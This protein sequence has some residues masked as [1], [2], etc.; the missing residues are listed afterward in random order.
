[1]PG[2]PGLVSIPLAYPNGS[3]CLTEIRYVLDRPFGD[4]FLGRDWGSS[5][6]VFG[7]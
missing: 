3:G 6:L 7:D 1:L 4:G 2:E 5:S